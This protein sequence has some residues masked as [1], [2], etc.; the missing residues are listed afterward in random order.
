[1]AGAVLLVLLGLVGISYRF[2]FDHGEGGVFSREEGEIPSL[3]EGGRDLER[4]HFAVRAASID[5]A[6][7]GFE[8]AAQLA[9]EYVDF[10]LDCGYVDAVGV[11]VANP[12]RAGWG[13]IIIWAGQARAR[14]ELAADAERIRSLTFRGTS[15]FVAAYPELFSRPK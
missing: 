5:Y 7:G 10:L 9:Q 15:P 14:D 13:K 3:P 12:K 1:M 4:D 6:R 2:G 11:P 8:S